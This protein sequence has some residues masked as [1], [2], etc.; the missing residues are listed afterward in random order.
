MLCHLV[1]G[2]YQ[3]SV[4]EQNTTGPVQTW[5]CENAEA[6][7]KPELLSVAGTIVFNSVIARRAGLT[8]S[9]PGVAFSVLQARPSSKIESQLSQTSEVLLSS[10]TAGPFYP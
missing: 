1:S 3:I 9:L 6:P 4:L 8:Y 10:T 2:E 7:W 5:V